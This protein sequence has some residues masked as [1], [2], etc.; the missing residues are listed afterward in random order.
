MVERRIAAGVLAGV[1]VAAALSTTVFWKLA[2]TRA[3]GNAVLYDKSGVSVARAEGASRAAEVV[4]ASIPGGTLCV[5]PIALARATKSAILAAAATATTSAVLLTLFAIAMLRRATAHVREEV[6]REHAEQLRL[7][8]VEL[9]RRTYELEA[10]NKDLESFAHTVSHD[11]RGPLG[12]IRGFGE[13]LRDG[14][15]GELNDEGRESVR[16]ILESA[17]QM[18]SLI[19]GLLQM[20]RLSRAELERDDVDLSAIAKGIATSL[21]KTAPDREVEF[22]ITDD[23]VANGDERLL[24][25]VMENLMTNAWKFTSKRDRARI[26]FGRTRDNGH[27]AYYVRDNGAGFDPAHAPKM[28]RP[29]QRLHS[30]KEFEGTGIGLAT[31]QRILQRHGGKAWA[32]GEPGKGATI[33]FTTEGVGSE[34]PL[35]PPTANRQ[36]PTRP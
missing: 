23:V 28:F 16:W 32:E 31:V 6:E 29:F 34:P 8:E 1:L 2:D 35:P 15:G 12:G 13:A 7:R 36:P 9:R 11:L 14:F 30:S 10:A 27:V 22:A 18:Q 24:R 20:S 17:D 4:C 19:D 3:A 26:E 21:Q 5:E 25:A 33:Y